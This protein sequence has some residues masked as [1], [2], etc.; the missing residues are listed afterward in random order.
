[1]SRVRVF[2]LAVLLTALAGCS[3][4]PDTPLTMAAAAGDEDQVRALLSGRADPN[5]PDSHGWSALHWAIRSG[6]IGAMR[7]LLEAGADVDARDEGCNGW[8]PLMTAIHKDRTD[9]ALLLLEAGADVDARSP[10]GTT[11]LIMA[12]GYGHTDTVR[13]LLEHGADPYAE[14]A[15]GLNALWSAA[16]GGAIGDFADGPPLGTC[17][18][19]TIEL[20][21]ERAPDL[22]LKDNFW[23]SIL[24]WLARSEECARIIDR[25]RQA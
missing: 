1:M 15:P 21:R 22:E 3:A 12:A 10:G 6:Q 7:A 20:L 5:E 13:T 23:T 19:D 16:G 2:E 17:F 24:S 9:L 8:T 4:R 18:P 25:L 11:G 14:S